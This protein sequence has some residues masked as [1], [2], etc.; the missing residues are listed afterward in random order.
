MGG[1]AVETGKLRPLQ[2][3]HKRLSRLDQASSRTA[4]HNAEV[5]RQLWEGRFDGGDNLLSGYLWTGAN[6]LWGVETHRLAGPMP[7]NWRVEKKGF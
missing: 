7:P 2:N 5:R 4:T 1:A 6:K 3:T